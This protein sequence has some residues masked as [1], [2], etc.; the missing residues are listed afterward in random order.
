MDLNQAALIAGFIV[1]V[2]AI[3][4]YV[5]GAF[6]WLWERVKGKP[7]AEEAVPAPAPKPEPAPTTP[8][9]L[10]HNLPYPPNPNFTGREGLLKAVR[11]ALEGGEATAL[12]Q[13]IVG[14]GGVGKT[15]LALEY[16]YRRAEDYSVIWWVR[17]EE[18]AQLASDYAALAA[19]RDLPEKDSPDQT[20]TIEAVRRWLEQNSGWLLIFDNAPKR[21]AVY[22]Y[23][24]HGGDGH[25]L[26]TSQDQAW[27]EVAKAV[28]VPEFPRPESV[29]FLKK[30][31]GQEEGAE[32]LAEAV[33]DLPLA[34]EQAAAYVE[35]TK[36][37]LGDYVALF[38]TRRREL[39]EKEKPPAGY[40]E[41]VGT[42]WAMAMERAKKECAPATDLLNLCAFLAPDD[43]PLDVIRE[44]ADDLP[45]T[46]A[47]VVGDQLALNEVA[48]AL[49]RYSLVMV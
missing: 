22:E 12:T 48:A 45:N 33:G 23:L 30:R 13:A 37:T 35:A 18:A 1:A 7:K 27:G 19:A 8:P 25:V 36:C 49:R 20:V 9:S 24:P 32:E 11:E 26:I 42:T 10:I 31:T 34:L 28:S 46:L 16:A 39:W 2:L 41:T 47:E 5:F 40:D 6:R 44:H 4:G 15:Q 43:I 38:E 3:L 14:L 21:E 29:E 17:S